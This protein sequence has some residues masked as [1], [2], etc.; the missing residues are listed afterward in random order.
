MPK[1]ADRLAP[2]WGHWLN[3]ASVT[4]QE[5]CMLTLNLEPRLSNKA[6][7][8]QM[9]LASEEVREVTNRLRG[10][11]DRLAEMERA[12]RSQQLISTNIGSIP[13]D[14]RLI[15]VSLRQVLKWIDQLAEPWSFPTQMNKLQGKKTRA[16]PDDPREIESYQRLFIALV[17]DKYNYDPDGSNALPKTLESKLKACGLKLGNH[18]IRKCLKESAELL[19][20]EKLKKLKEKKL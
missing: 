1:T 12:V 4:A 6:F 7:A 3:M 2:D 9:R 14:P 15:T 13:A 11:N 18:T 16:K 8:K 20:A 10:L 5:A 17:F 19:S